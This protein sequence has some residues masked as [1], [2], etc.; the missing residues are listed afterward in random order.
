MIDRMNRSSDQVFESNQNINISM[1]SEAYTASSQNIWR[2]AQ[3]SG[4][5][6][7]EQYLPQMI[8]CDDDAPRESR[9]SGS[10]LAGLPNPFGGGGESGL[11]QLPQ[12]PQLPGLPGMG[13]GGDSSCNSSSSS[14][15]TTKDVMQLA[16]TAA[17][18]VLGAL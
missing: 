8:I 7:S 4:R 12:L 5:G 10:P 13:G 15:A 1:S 11:P 18:L 14:D 17:P 16:E 9:Q 6:G 3:S 2:D